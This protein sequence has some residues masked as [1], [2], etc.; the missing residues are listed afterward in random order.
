MIDSGLPEI[1]AGGVRSRCSE[2]PAA[3][4]IPAGQPENSLPRGADRRRR[5]PI[6]VR[7]LV[8]VEW[9]SK[10]PQSRQTAPTSSVLKVDS[11]TDRLTKRR[12]APL[13]RVQEAFLAEYFGIALASRYSGRSL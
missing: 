7:P 3:S 4:T 2:R 10:P 8:D 6:R 5:Y 13:W 11:A 9:R 12:S 1:R